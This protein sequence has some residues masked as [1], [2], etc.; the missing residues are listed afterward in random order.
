MKGTVVFMILTV[1]AALLCALLLMLGKNTLWGWA[2]TL[3]AFVALIV[4][5]V[6][7]V[8]G[9]F[10]PRLALWVGF[11]AVL[12][13]IYKLSGPPIKAIPAVEGKDPTPTG[14]VTVA[15]GDLTGVY[16]QDGGVEV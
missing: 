4:V 15:Q 6:R 11:L 5:R 14:V 1:L 10:L 3:A 8:T 13:L 16:T 12:A 9:G 7:F 2:L